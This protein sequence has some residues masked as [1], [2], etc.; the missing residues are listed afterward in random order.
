MIIP[1]T[2]IGHPSLRLENK[3]VQDFS[4]EKVQAV[5]T[6]LVESMRHVG[7]IGM[8]A[9]QIAEN[10]S[11]FITEPRQTETRPSSQ[12]DQLRIYINPKIVDRSDQSIVI[13]EG[14][15]SI[16]HGTIFGPVSRPKW[17]TV[18]ALDLDGNSFRITADGIL[19]RV[20]QHEYDHLNGILFT[21]I[22]TDP[23]K[24]IDIEYYKKD[25]KNNPTEIDN[26]NIT[27]NQVTR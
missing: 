4:D 2:Q 25:I 23:Q 9:P 5:I 15:G 13:Y 18:Q 8:A 24:L 26:C 21:D 11:I 6:N 20:I 16:S 19:G 7:L 12:S 3:K 22:L 27:I 1:T 14:C 17:I 10:Y